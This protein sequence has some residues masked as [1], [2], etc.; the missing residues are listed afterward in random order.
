MPAKSKQGLLW[1]SVVKNAPCN[2]RE[3]S[4]IPGQGTT[5]P[6]T[7]KQ[8]SLRSITTEP[9]HPQL[10]NPWAVRKRRSCMTQQRS[11]C[12]EEINDVCKMFLK[13]QKKQTNP[14]LLLCKQIDNQQEWQSHSSFWNEWFLV[15]WRNIW[16]MWLMNWAQKFLELGIR[17]RRGWISSFLKWALSR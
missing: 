8:L 11:Q 3:M 1:W 7:T 13:N 4:L 16:F 2:A 17:T 12:S 9:P 5:I 14:P 6:Y 15:I 10:K